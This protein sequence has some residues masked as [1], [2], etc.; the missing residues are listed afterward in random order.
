MYMKFY[1]LEEEPFGLT[2]DPRFIFETESHL[3]ALA[4]LKYGIE[5]N[6]SLIL[7]TGESG[8]GKTTTLRAVIRDFSDDILPVYLFNPF[9][10]APEF[11]EYLA[12]ELGIKFPRGATKPEILSALG[13]FL[14]A[15]H[16]KGL[17]TLLII[18]EAHGLPLELLEESRLLLNFETNSEKLIQIIL[19]GQPE[20]QDSLNR[21]NMRQLKQRVSLRCNIKPLSVFE[22]GNYIR[23][24]LKTAGGKN[25]NLFDNS[26]VGLIAHASQGIPRVVNNICDNALLYGYASGSAIIN[27]DIIA[28]V[29]AALDIVPMAA[30]GNSSSGFGEE[31]SSGD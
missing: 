27:R 25:L 2:P 23:S 31:M 5:H 17:R 19:S 4:T 8:S 26:A 21:P 20:L 14:A 24:R 9:L 12:T 11:F 13:R 1:E 18:D 3:E 6:K 28:D 30:T 16:S 7:L 10:T 29:I 15:R 22:I